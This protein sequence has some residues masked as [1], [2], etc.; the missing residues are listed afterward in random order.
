MHD[1][2]FWRI[3][4][5]LGLV[6]VLYVGHG[7]HKNESG[8]PSLSNAAYAGGVGILNG[9]IYTANQSGTELTMWT[10]DNRGVP[11]YLTTAKVH[12][13]LKVNPVENK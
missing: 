8:I 3:L 2:K 5:V 1:S 13:V 11:K 7:L 6:G 12:A 4:A 10:T 9:V